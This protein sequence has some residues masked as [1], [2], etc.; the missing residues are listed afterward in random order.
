MNEKK[1]VIYTSNKKKYSNYNNL[2][3]LESECVCVR[4]RE[5]RDLINNTWV[6]QKKKI[7][8]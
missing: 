2:K 3:E 1:N 6:E 7:Y 4:E 8:L 5:R